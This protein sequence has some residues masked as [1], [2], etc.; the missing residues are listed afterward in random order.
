MPLAICAFLLSVLCSPLDASEMVVDAHA[1]TLQWILY[2]NTNLG[3]RRAQGHWDIPRARAGGVK[4][5]VL[6]LWVD[7]IFQGKEAVRQ[8]ERL[9]DCAEKFLRQNKNSVRLIRTV[10]DLDEVLAEGKI[11]IV[12]SI[13]G[14]HAISGSLKNLQRFFDRGVRAMTLTWSN[15]NEIGDSS[16]DKG[17]HGGLSEFGKRVVSEMERLGMIVDVSHA[18]D[19]TFRDVLRIVQKPVLASHSSCRA[20]TRHHRNLTDEMLRALGENGGVVA[21]NFY[22]KF[23]D[24]KTR[25]RKDSKKSPVPPRRSENLLEQGRRNFYEIWDSSAL[26]RPSLSALTA[27]IQHAVSIAGENHVGLGSDFDGAGNMPHGMD[28]PQDFPNMARALRKTGFS[29]GRI[30]KIFSKNLIRLFRE[31]FPK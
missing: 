27:H 4:I 20:L 12:L 28:G 9:L 25:K 10:R 2:E 15:T 14:G 13:E 3:K 22:S 19:K 24:E 29:Q 21:I 11:G 16:G 7:S 5:Q 30:E 1:D 26:P 23:L 6:A 8:T 31:T 18:S 17:R